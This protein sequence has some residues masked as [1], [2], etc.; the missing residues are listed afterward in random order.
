[1]DIKTIKKL[2]KAK[3]EVARLWREMCLF[4]RVGTDCKFVVFSKENPFFVPY[5]K[6]VKSMFRAIN[7]SNLAVR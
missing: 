3:A 4:D 1:M 5:N 7:A 2:N 6:A